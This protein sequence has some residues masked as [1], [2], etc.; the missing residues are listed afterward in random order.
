LFPISISGSGN[1]QLYITSIDV[2][3]NYNKHNSKFSLKITQQQTLKYLV[4]KKGKQKQIIHFHFLQFP[5]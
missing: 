1:L 4:R 2:Q 3:V 5:S